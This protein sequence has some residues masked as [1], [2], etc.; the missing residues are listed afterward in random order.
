[1]E[2]A[3]KNKL[4]KITEAKRTQRKVLVKRDEHDYRK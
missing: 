2:K 4:V 1:M 3:K